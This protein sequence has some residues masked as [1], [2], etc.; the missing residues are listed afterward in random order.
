MS[1][2]SFGNF[3]VKEVSQF[4]DSSEPGIIATQ[5]KTTAA[6]QVLPLVE[7]LK[8]KSQTKRLQAQK[9]AIPE[10]IEYC[11]NY[12]IFLIQFLHTEDLI[13][14]STHAQADICIDRI[15]KHVRKI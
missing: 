8:S 4:S 15:K 10:D 2:N 11:L 6:Q 12:I 7:E 13:T 5:K 9:E 14:P 3:N 1:V